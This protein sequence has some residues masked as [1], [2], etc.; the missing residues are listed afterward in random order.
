MY[1]QLKML[2]GKPIEQVKQEV[3]LMDI[4]K[5]EPIKKKTIN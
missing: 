1:E 2:D 4:P 5:T 3:L